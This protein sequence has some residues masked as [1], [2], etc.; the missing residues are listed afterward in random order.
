MDLNLEDVLLKDVDMI[1]WKKLTT[2]LQ[3]ENNWKRLVE[4]LP[5]F[6]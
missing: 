2:A 3:K 6:E 4:Y 1:T 5:L